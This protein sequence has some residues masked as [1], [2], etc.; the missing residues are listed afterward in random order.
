[1]NIH[2][3]KFSRRDFLKWSSISLGALLLSLPK[4]SVESRYEPKYV[5]VGNPKGVSVH[6][7]PTDKSIIIYRRELDDIIHVYDDVIGTDGPEYNPLWYRVWGGYVHSA[8]L[9]EVKFLYNEIAA[10]VNSTGQ[11]AEVTVPFTRSL[12]YNSF[13]GWNPQ[14]RF[15]YGS[16]H[17]IVDIISGPDNRPWYKVKD[18]LLKVELAVSAEHLRY[19]PDSELTPISPDVLPA[20]K[21]IEISLFRQVLTAYES[22]QK[23]METKIS[24]GLPGGE[25]A[26][27][28]GRFHIATKMPS[29][30]MGDGKLT[31]DIY[32]YE[33]M[34]VPWNCFFE[35]E[36]GV[37]THGTY[38]HNNFG[39]QMS[40]G[41]VNMR[42]SDAKWLYRWTY[43]I[44]SPDDWEKHG[45]GTPIEVI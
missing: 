2:S 1:M 34:G 15:Y 24:S 26:T 7:N 6:K 17:W 44:A 27:P 45:Y 3:S 29:K 28:T 13:T 14:Y 41:C 35:M 30:H 43:P 19:I 16:V 40:H 18:E 25:L 23:V 22:G 4:N 8:N 20:N 33:L 10:T 5:M 32:A 36:N 37:A 38:W 9:V 31:D 21:K 11:L 12:F 39:S 42:T